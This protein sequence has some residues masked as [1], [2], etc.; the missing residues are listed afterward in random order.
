MTDWTPGCCHPT[1]GPHGKGE[2]QTCCHVHVEDLPSNQANQ[3]GEA[4]LPPEGWT[5]QE[6]D[7]ADKLTTEM[8]KQS[9]EEVTEQLRRHRHSV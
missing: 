5:A 2:P 1:S 8:A 4:P 6:Q 3:Q 7:L 9:D